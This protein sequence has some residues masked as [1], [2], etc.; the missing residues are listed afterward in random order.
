[1]NARRLGFIVL[2]LVLAEVAGLALLLGNRAPEAPSK[3][4]PGAGFAAYC[5]VLAAADPSA[6]E[7]YVD[8]PFLGDGVVRGRVVDEQ[9]APAAG[10]DVFLTRRPA[11]LSAADYPHVT[12]PRWAAKTDAAG[13]FCFDRLPADGFMAAAFAP[14]AHAVAT[15]LLA[16]NGPAVELEMTLSP[17]VRVSGRVVAADGQPVEQALVYAVAYADGFPLAQPY[18]YFP[19]RAGA[20][21]AFRF[22]HLRPGSWAVLVVDRKYAPSLSGP[23]DAERP[24]AEI[25]VTLEQGAQVAGRLY[26]ADSE[27]ALPWVRLVAVE[28]AWGI[29][30]T[31]AWTDAQGEFTFSQLRPAEYRVR[32]ATNRHVL[33]DDALAAGAPS[34]GAVRLSAVRAGGI[35]GRVVCVEPPNGGVA[36]VEVIA[37]DPGTGWVRNA[38]TDQG[39]YYRFEALPEGR[40]RVD[41]RPPFGRVPAGGL[42]QDIAVAS[43]A[44]SAADKVALA[45]ALPARGVVQDEKGAPAPYANVYAYVDRADAG[46]AA[47]HA[48]GQGRFECRAAARGEQVRVWAEV[49]GVTSPVSVAFTPG[50]DASPLRLVLSETN[51]CGIDGRVVNAQGQAV[52]Y[53][54]VLCAH[55]NGRPPRKAAADA[56]GRFRIGGLAPGDYRLT[57]GYGPEAMAGEAAKTITLAPEDEA[58]SVRLVL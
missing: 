8:N 48:D 33:I 52:P 21:G 37:E 53:A 51:R 29:E 18:Q 50:P 1:M 6:L 12:T 19:V 25:V 22:E 3:P 47:V 15:T 14:R 4:A 13:F 44:R 16:P 36:G 2:A 45:E 42:T 40:Y 20:G 35:R 43:G 5:G 26:D 57:P 41:V 27:Q 54:N 38:C 58:A 55:V 24:T 10:A 28:A 17:S 31:S 11:G 34:P 32:A 23:F 49:M 7:R 9:G 46:V 30:E 56:D 39:G